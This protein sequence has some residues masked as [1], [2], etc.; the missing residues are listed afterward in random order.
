M[1]HGRPIRNTGA[2]DP[3]E[4]GEDERARIHARLQAMDG[5]GRAGNATR[6]IGAPAQQ[7]TPAYDGSL[8]QPVT[9]STAT[10]SGLETRAFF[11]TAD[12][13]VLAELPC[14]EAAG[15]LSLGRG[16]SAHIRVID[17]YVHRHHAEIRW[18]AGKNAHLIAHGGGENGTYVNR[19]RVK[20]PLML[21][22]GEQIRIGKT[23]LT[24]RIRR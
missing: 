17:P 14:D 20:L 22:G 15:T 7:R 6:R 16:E 3:G 21:V 9:H 18:D 12:G 11:L 10:A 23:R 2:A 4:P 13:G 19:H 24:Y 8:A 1:I 5:S